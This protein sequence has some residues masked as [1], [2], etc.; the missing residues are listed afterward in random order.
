MIAVEIF[1][2]GSLANQHPMLS[3]FSLR[4]Q[5]TSDTFTKIT[6]ETHRIKQ[7][8]FKSIDTTLIILGTE[9]A[10]E[11]IQPQP[12]K[13]IFHRFI[14][15]HSVVLRQ[16][17]GIHLS[18]TAPCSFF[19]STIQAGSLRSNIIFLLILLTG[20]KTERAGRLEDDAR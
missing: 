5:S 20:A 10:Q 16:E 19:D 17:G 12:P 1:R 13:A 3:D 15:H 8:R 14:D 9:I 18:F 11:S 7:S 4:P 6:T 2:H